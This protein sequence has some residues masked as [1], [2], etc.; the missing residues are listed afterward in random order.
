M[1]THG[2]QLAGCYSPKFAIDCV[3]ANVNKQLEADGCVLELSEAGSKLTTP[4]QMTAG[5]YVKVRLW[6]NGEEAVVDIRLAEVREVNN[7][8][9]KVE[10]IQVSPN[11]RTRM[12][13]LIDTPAAVHIKQ[14][15]L[16]D[17]LLIRA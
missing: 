16:I 9:I 7:H 11:D 1:M 17:H 4:D 6:L 13:R 8:W 3:L 2:N 5:D 14:P 12:K 10:V 15:V